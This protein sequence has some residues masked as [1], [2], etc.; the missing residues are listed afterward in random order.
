MTQQLTVQETKVQ[1]VKQLLHQN[2]KSILAALPKQIGVDRFNRI[3][4]TSVQLTPGLMDCTPQS[5]LSAVLTCAQLGLEPD[6]VRNMAHL[7]PFGKKVTFIPGYMGLIDLAMRSGQF[8]NINAH[9]V[10]RKDEF[11]YAHGSQPFIHHKP[12]FEDHPGQPIAAYCIA[13]F[14]QGG[15]QF[16]VLPMSKIKEVQSRSPA[17]KSGPWITDFDAMALKTAIRHSVK[18]LPSSVV[19]NSLSLA[20]SLDERADAGIDQQLEVLT[21]VDLQTG[22]ITEEPGKTSL[23]ALA[24][25]HGAPPGPKPVETP[26]EP[27]P[28]APETDDEKFIAEFFSLRTPGFTD[29][30][31]D[32]QNIIRLGRLPENSPVLK[33][34]DDKHMRFWNTP[35]PRPSF[36][37]PH[38]SGP[39]SMTEPPPQPPLFGEGKEPEDATPDELDQKMASIERTLEIDKFVKDAGIKLKSWHDWAILTARMVMGRYTGYFSHC[40]ATDPDTEFVAFGK[41]QEEANERQEP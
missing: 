11:D 27:E 33:E 24:E 37:S 17:G 22:E 3:V 16:R 7:V 12:T 38:P 8:I 13:F 29:Y 30:L 9:I 15:F 21:G 39:L 10:F 18:Y 41:F 40:F 36:A 20:V 25:K 1:S 26:K 19:D 14:K 28:V 31:A 2:S 6:G 5:L 4:M 23:D 34:L 32:E 35:W